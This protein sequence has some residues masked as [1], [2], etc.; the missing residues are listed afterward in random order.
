VDV[1]GLATAEANLVALTLSA[2]AGSK[3]AMVDVSKDKPAPVDICQPDKKNEWPALYDSKTEWV[4]FQSD[5]DTPGKSHIFKMSYKEKVP[6]KLTAGDASFMQPSVETKA[7][8]IWY[9]GNP[10][11]NWALFRF[12]ISSYAE[13]Q[14][15]MG[16]PGRD[17]KAP[18]PSAAGD[19]VAYHASSGGKSVLEVTDLRSGKVMFSAPDAVPDTAIVWSPD[20]EKI[21]YLVKDGAETRMALTHVAKRVTIVLPQ[22]VV[23]RS[24]AWL[25]D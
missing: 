24:F 9:A 22:P 10:G 8:W 14:R 23:G 1:R 18:A 5:R 19:H 7:R 6:A 2:G 17:F 12:Q 4:F 15:R 25:H 3:L 16:T 13:P 20:D 11:G 21:G